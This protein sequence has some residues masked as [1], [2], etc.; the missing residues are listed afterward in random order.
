MMM[1][2]NSWYTA[3]ECYKLFNSEARYNAD[4]YRA[5]NKKTMQNEQMKKEKGKEH[6]GQRKRMNERSL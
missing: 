1:E 5:G 6:V 4:T 2:E 3:E